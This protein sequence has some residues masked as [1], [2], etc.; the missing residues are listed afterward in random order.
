V[1]AIKILMSAIAVLLLLQSAPS[2]GSSEMLGL[3]PPS[4]FSETPNTEFAE[5]IYIYANLRDSL[6]GVNNFNIN[7][8]RGLGRRGM[9]VLL[10][11]GRRSLC[12]IFFDE[13]RE[14]EVKAE[15]AYIGSG[16]YFTRAM[17]DGKSYYCLIL[18]D[19]QRPGRV[20]SV[21]SDDIFAYAVK[22]GMV[23]I[24]PHRYREYDPCAPAA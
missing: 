5:T 11:S 7:Y 24:K 23:K 8:I 19:M 13:T 4:R 16:Q 22:V 3:S 17:I 20:M 14:C 15:D 6:K 2:N 9:E 18:R 1:N 12:V 10:P 21:V